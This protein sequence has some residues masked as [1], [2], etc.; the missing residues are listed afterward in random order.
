MLASAKGRSGSRR[1]RAAECRRRRAAPPASALARSA[2]RASAPKQRSYRARTSQRR[3]S[4]ARSRRANRL[5]EL[6][7]AI[8]RFEPLDRL[9][10]CRRPLALLSKGR[11][12]GFYDVAIARQLQ[13]ARA[14]V[15]ALQQLRRQVH[16]G[17]HRANINRIY[18]TTTRGALWALPGLC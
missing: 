1:P 5:L 6:I 10:K 16:G 3:R 17:R 13:G 15:D 18:R 14:L 4:L 11:A 8:D 7:H 12:Q 9:E 2:R